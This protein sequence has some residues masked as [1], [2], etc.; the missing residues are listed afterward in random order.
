VD[1]FDGSLREP[2]VLPSAVPNLLVNGATGIAVGLP[3]L[4]TIWLKSAMR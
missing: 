1:N 3:S 2:V 4:P